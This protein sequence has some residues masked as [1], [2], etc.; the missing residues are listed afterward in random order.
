[1]STTSVLTFSAWARRRP[2]LVLALLLVLFGAF[3]LVWLGDAPFINDEPRLLGLALEANRTG[4]LA[5]RG[6]MGSRGVQYGPFAV[7]FYQAALKI[8]HDPV[9]LVGIRAFLVTLVTG[10]SLFWIA[11]LLPRL[12]A[13][14]GA[15]AFLSPYLWFYSRQLWDNSFCIPLSALA[16]ASYLAFTARPRAWVLVVTALSLTFMFLTHLMSLAVILPIL[17]HFVWVHRKW[18]VRRWWVAGLLAAG[19]FLLSWG[20]ISYLLG[21]PFKP[22]PAAEQGSGWLFP[23]LGGRTFSVVG[24]DYFLGKNWT[25]GAVLGA[26]DASRAAVVLASALSYLLVWAGIVLCARQVLLVFRKKIEG[27]VGADLFFHASLLSLAVLASQAL[28]F[29]LAGTSGHPHYYNATWIFCFFFLWAALSDPVWRGWGRAAGAA[30]GAVLA[31][32][33]F[34]FA[35]VIHARGGTRGVHYGPTIANQVEVVKKIA[36]YS[37]DSNL[38]CQVDHWMIFPKAFVLLNNLAGGPGDPKGPK[39]DLVIEYARKDPSSGRIRVVEKK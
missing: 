34:D 15:L 39:A 35:L 33:L 25:A 38:D 4:A 9:A 31:L 7:W 18:I 27:E 8:T 14:L 6:I 17:G 2:Y 36:T 21:A 3:R 13:P 20:Y 24:L 32:A 30:L 22:P 16:F 19:A 23:L 29:G 26:K 1:M 11:R 28:L 12:V 37:P 5:S 10:L